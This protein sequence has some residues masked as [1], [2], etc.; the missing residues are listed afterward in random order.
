MHWLIWVWVKLDDLCEKH[1][2]HGQV[3]LTNKWLKHIHRRFALFVKYAVL[4]EGNII[5]CCT[6]SRGINLGRSVGKIIIIFSLRVGTSKNKNI[7]HR[8]KETC[9]CKSDHMSLLHDSKM[10]RCQVTKFLFFI[11]FI[12]TQKKKIILKGK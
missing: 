1:S 9:T 7:D 5:L 3:R 4:G 11:C 12:T 10:S 6:G 8:G 2:N